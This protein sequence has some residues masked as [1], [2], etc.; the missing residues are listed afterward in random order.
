MTR[1]I[2]AALFFP[3]FS[4]A[5]T[6]REME[7]RLFDAV[8]NQRGHIGVADLIWNDALAD[9]ARVQSV[10]MMER[11]F[12]AH[13]D[14]LRGDLAA[15]LDSAGVRWLRCGENL[16]TEMGFIE[17]VWTAIVEWMHSPGHKESLLEPD[18]THSGVGIA[19][20]AEARY[21]MTQ[22]FTKPLPN[23][24]INARMNARTARKS[25]MR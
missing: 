19:R 20:T 10:N 22:I 13:V 23:A 14:P 1:R 24:R 21:F 15:R 4:R 25:H 7:K 12:F 16:F 3:A 11:G 9:A 2:F 8:N 17:P 6:L 5:E 18:Y